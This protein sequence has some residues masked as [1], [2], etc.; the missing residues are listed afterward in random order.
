[1]VFLLINLSYSF[2]SVIDSINKKIL[3]SFNKEFSNARDIKWENKGNFFLATFFLNDEV[4]F[5]RYTTNGQ[6]ISLKRNIRS[7]KL[8]LLPS[9]NLKKNYKGY[10]ISGL[11]EQ[12]CY[13]QTTYYATLENADHKLVLKSVNNGNWKVYSKKGKR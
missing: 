11:F 8:P 13:N 7:D 3:S 6:L 12:S 5:A 10:W 4:L 9:L 1:M 2:A